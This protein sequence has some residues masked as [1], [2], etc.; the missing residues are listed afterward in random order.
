MRCLVTGAS[1]GIGRAI[2]ES[3]IAEGAQVAVC[4]SSAAPDVRGAVLSVR[5]DVAEEEQVRGFFEQA[6]KPDCVVINAGVLERGPI[7]EFSAAQ[8]DRV[9]AVNLRGA[10]LCAREGFR[11]GA[12]RIVAVGSISGTLGTAHSAAYNASKWGLTGLIKSLAEEGRDRGIFCAAVLPGSVDTA[13]LKKTPYS[14][15]MTCD[16]VAR[17][18]KF[19]CTEAPFA[20]TGSA[21][22]VFG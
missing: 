6:G 4:A 5:A 11:R 13:M 21:V 1:R 7:E 22:E 9:H 2:A 19:L 17:V 3:L 15:Q 8:W 12:R 10:F 18:V 16:D 20:M 14:P